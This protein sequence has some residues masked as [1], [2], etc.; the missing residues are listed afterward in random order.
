MASTILNH[1]IERL[2]KNSDMALVFEC[3]DPFQM[4][5]ERL[6]ELI[7]LAKQKEIRA[8]LIGLAD[9][10][11]VYRATLPQHLVS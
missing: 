8:Y 3:E 7:A 9:M 11:R 1:P 4:S 2:A 5:D 6:C 10:R